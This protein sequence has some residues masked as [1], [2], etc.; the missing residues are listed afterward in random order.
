MADT[1]TFTENTFSTENDQDA[2]YRQLS[3]MAIWSIPFGLASALAMVSPLL[4]FV[5]VVAVALAFGGLWQISRSNE[6]TGRRLALTGL[7]LGVLFGSWGMSWTI[8]RRAVIERQARAHAIEWLGMMQQQKFMQAHQLS[9][10]YYDRLPAGSSLEEYYQDRLSPEVAEMAAR[11]EA[12]GMGEPPGMPGA[13]QSPLA[14]LQG[15]M[16]HGIP[17]IL[18]DANGDFEFE[19]VR[20]DVQLRAGQFS[21]KVDQIFHLTFADDHEPREMDVKVEMKR[22]ID[23]RKAYWQV[24]RL[25]DP[26]PPPAG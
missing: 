18:V 9:M 19:F 23:V 3:R 6:I 12:A 8:S 2:G 14:D 17:Q 7:A 5:P 4:W 10:N 20:F 21:T 1:Q 15:F 25:S 13:M 16:A 24:E 22:T 26:K 11:A